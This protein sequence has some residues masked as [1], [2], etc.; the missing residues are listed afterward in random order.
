MDKK[1]F[2]NKNHRRLLCKYFIIYFNFVS[3]F[4]TIKKKESQDMIFY[5]FSSKGNW[6]W[7]LEV[8]KKF[9]SL[10]IILPYQL[11]KKPGKMN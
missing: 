8:E 7:E 4:V 6:N 3:L 5:T 2:E 9:Y 1:L 10:I 11:K